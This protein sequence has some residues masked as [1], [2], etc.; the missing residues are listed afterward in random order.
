MAHFQALFRSAAIHPL[1][2]GRSFLE[3]EYTKNRS[4]NVQ[5]YHDEQSTNS[6]IFRFPFAIPK[7]PPKRHRN[8]IGQQHNAT[9]DE[10]GQPNS[11]WPKKTVNGRTR[12]QSADAPISHGVIGDLK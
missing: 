2:F 4:R 1:L 5:T 9:V 10:F 8:Y 7:P 6:P 12:K 11:L 3:S